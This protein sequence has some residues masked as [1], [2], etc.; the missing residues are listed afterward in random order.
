[1]IPAKIRKFA[2]AAYFIAA[3]AAHTA[4]ADLLD[5]DD[6]GKTKVPAAT[7]TAPGTASGEGSPA[8][9]APTKNDGHAKTDKNGKSG[10]ADR[11]PTSLPKDERETTPRK[12]SQTVLLPK[13]GGKKKKE[14]KVKPDAELPVQFESTGLKGLREKGFVELIDNVVVTQGTMRIE[15]KHATVSYDEAT[16]EVVKVLAEGNVKMFKDDEDSGEKIKAYGDQMVFLNRERTTTLDGNARL[17]RGAN[18]VRGSK[19]IYDMKSGL[20]RGEH[21]AGEVHPQ[22]LQEK[23]KDNTP[24]DS[25]SGSA[26]AAG[27]GGGSAVEA[28]PKTRSVTPAVP[29]SPTAEA[30]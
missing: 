3:F 20:I 28:P 18:L 5:D 29:A 4:Y 17:W 12:G 25:G 21:V 26:G 14:S 13:G 1:M 15:A 16:K 2:P 10:K 19:I 7:V 6:D 24:A 9:A 8:A 11:K 30:P 27:S 23:P 22:D